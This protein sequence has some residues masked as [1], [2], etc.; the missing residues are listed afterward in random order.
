MTR[1]RVIIGQTLPCPGTGGKRRLGR[2]YELAANAL[3]FSGHMRRSRSAGLA[4]DNHPNYLDP[5]VVIGGFM[6][7]FFMVPLALGVK[8]RLT[9]T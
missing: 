9:A 1:T 6:S 7:H 5:V 3:A 8:K 4:S 2:E